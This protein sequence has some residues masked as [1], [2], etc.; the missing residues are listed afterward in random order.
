MRMIKQLTRVNP[1]IAKSQV[2]ARIV[3]TPLQRGGDRDETTRLS[4]TDA[5]A[6]L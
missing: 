4:L 6:C 1:F 2:V 5:L 3:K